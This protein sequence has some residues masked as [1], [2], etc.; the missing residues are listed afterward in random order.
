MGS[1]RGRATGINQ[2][3]F[4]A[5]GIFALAMTNSILIPLVGNWR[6]T[7]L[8]YGLMVFLI[9]I[10]WLFM[11]RRTPS[12]NTSGFKDSN[13]SAKS[14]NI[15][16]VKNIFKSKNI[17]LIVIIGITSFLSSH[18]LS[19]WLP[20]IFESKGMTPEIAGSTTAVLNIFGI[21]G[22][23]L[24][25]ELP[26]IVK[27]KKLAISILLFMT[28]LSIFAL[29]IVEGPALWLALALDGISKGGFLPL[30]IVTL[31][32]MPEVG[33]SRMGVVGGLYFAIGEI[34]GFGGPFIM[35]LLKDATGTF[36]SGILFLAIVCEAMI[37]AAAFLKLDKPLKQT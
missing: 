24:T 19:N 32:D 18:G 30:L 33:P 34:G 37:L 27:S 3:G 12:Y 6:N 8:T 25:P 4:T 28:G 11:G 16:S 15:S 9:G 1:E 13:S 31:M 21:F 22:C 7:Y 20:K 17:W 10:V 29:G 14:Q 23:F 35:G 26:R 2:T 36:L 5:G